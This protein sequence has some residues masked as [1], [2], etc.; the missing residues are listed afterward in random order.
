[1]WNKIK[2]ILQKSVDNGTVFFVVIAVFYFV[3]FCFSAT[4]YDDVAVSQETAAI[5]DLPSML[6]YLYYKD[7]LTWSSRIFVNFVVL[8]MLKMPKAVWSMTN[9]IMLFVMMY[10]MARLL[11]KD[12][13]KRDR[14]IVALSVLLFPINYLGTAGWIATM[15]TYFWPIAVAFTCLIPLRKIVND[16]PFKA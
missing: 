14:L 10:A 4:R 12:V 9:A 15:T 6:H 5:V 1:M 8:F 3:L 2:N 13:D 16:E 7:F 11:G